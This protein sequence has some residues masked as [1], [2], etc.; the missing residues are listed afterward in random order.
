[1]ITAKIVS[2]RDQEEP[3]NYLSCAS[4]PCRR[5]TKY[6]NPATGSVLNPQ[7]PNLSTLTCVLATVTLGVDYFVHQNYSAWNY[8]TSVC[9]NIELS[10]WGCTRWN[11]FEYFVHLETKLVNMGIPFTIG[12][13]VER[14]NRF[15]QTE[16]FPILGRHSCTRP[17]AV[18]SEWRSGAKLWTCDSHLCRFYNDRWLNGTWGP[19]R[20]SKMNQQMI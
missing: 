3:Q 17:D 4:S 11:G 19:K 20:H 14:T 5:W 10:G 9:M 7:P 12:I 18:R 8:S 2:K 13:T 15:W 1:M 16:D 6:S